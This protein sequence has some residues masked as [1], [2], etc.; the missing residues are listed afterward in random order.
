[1]KRKAERARAT[2][3]MR[4]A[5]KLMAKNVQLKDDLEQQQEAVAFILKQHDCNDCA[6]ASL[7]K[8]IPKWGEP[9]RINCPFWR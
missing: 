6:G 5:F 8:Y 7:C 9:V 1:M 4:L 2:Y 3:W